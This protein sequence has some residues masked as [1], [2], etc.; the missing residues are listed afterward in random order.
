MKM[1]PY[2]LFCMRSIGMKGIQSGEIKPYRDIGEQ[3]QITASPANAPFFE[4]N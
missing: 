3:I 2:R 4:G 1:A